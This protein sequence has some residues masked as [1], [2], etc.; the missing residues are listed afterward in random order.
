MSAEGV[1]L[2]INIACSSWPGL[3]IREVSAFRLFLSFIKEGRNG[4]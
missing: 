1:V 4:S 3:R 2:R